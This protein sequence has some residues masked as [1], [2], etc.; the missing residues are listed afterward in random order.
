MEEDEFLYLELRVDLDGVDSTIRAF[1]EDPM[2]A[3][4]TALSLIQTRSDFDKLP[5]YRQERASSALRALASELDLDPRMM[6][7]ERNQRIGDTNRILERE[8]AP[9]RVVTAL[10]AK[11][12]TAGWTV[13]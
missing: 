3:A 6:S 1:T 4:D 8:G 11:M 5:A 10:I 2:A 7:F 13:P 12:N 9:F